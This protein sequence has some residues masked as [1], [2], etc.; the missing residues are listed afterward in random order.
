MTLIQQRWETF[1]QRRDKAL[2]T[3]VRTLGEL[4]VVAVSKKQSPQVIATHIFEIEKFPR[5]LGE[6]YLQ[7]LQQ[8]V[9]HPELLPHDLEWHF[10]GALQ[11]R[12][13]AE[14]AKVAKVI[15]SV[16]RIKE[17]ESLAQIL[18]N[19]NQIPNFYLQFNASNESTKQ[20][21]DMNEAALAVETLDRLDLNDRCLGLM[22]TAAPVEHLTRKTFERLRIL[23][24]KHF[25]GK[26]LNMGMSSDFEIAIQEGTDLIRVGSM[27]FGERG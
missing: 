3:A 1:C 7:E 14:V 10:I 27:L 18:R 8:K 16:S 25:A 4:E 17:L 12:K 6:N 21:F 9:N 24:D 2:A 23:R 22:C 19:E 11:S 20:G 26:K 15:H 5:T 13:I